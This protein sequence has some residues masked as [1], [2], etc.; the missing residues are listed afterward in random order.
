MPNIRI[1]NAYF[2]A[3]MES[4]SPLS[5]E[6]SFEAHP[7]YLQLQFLPFLYSDPDD[8]IMLSHLPDHEYLHRLMQK[9]ITRSPKLRQS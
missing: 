5:L 8:I 1:A 7:I 3:E 6:R 2:E 4:T 9:G